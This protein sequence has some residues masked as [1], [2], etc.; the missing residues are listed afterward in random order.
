[1][2]AAAIYRNSSSDSINTT[3]SQKDLL[4]S[5]GPANASSQN[6]QAAAPESVGPAATQN[7][8]ADYL[9]GTS[10]PNAALPSG[11]INFLSPGSYAS[12][13]ALFSSSAS[14]SPGAVMPGA[15]AP[16]AA[17]MNV[18]ADQLQAAIYS[19][20]AGTTFNVSGTLIGQLVVPKSDI[21]IGAGFGI[22]AP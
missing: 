22:V 11:G 15:A 3:A 12:Y 14:S 7:P 5:A 19:D 2:S 10:A 9:F 8:G 17:A 16:N 13:S 1:L 20:P 21:I 18:T 4:F 6:G